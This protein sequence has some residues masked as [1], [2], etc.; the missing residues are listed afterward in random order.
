MGAQMN[1]AGQVHS[2][3]MYAAHANTSSAAWYPVRAAPKSLSTA[4]LFFPQLFRE[5]VTNTRSTKCF[6]SSLLHF[7]H[8]IFLFP[9]SSMDMARLNSAPHF[10]HS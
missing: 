7:G 4:D 3:G 8:R 5:V 9:C 1:A 10:L 6:T 2:Q